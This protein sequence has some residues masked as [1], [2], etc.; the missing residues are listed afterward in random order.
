MAAEERMK[1]AFDKYQEIQF[2]TFRQFQKFL[3]DLELDE[4]ADEIDEHFY[5]EYF[6]RNCCTSLIGGCCAKSFRR[7]RM[8]QVANS[9][10]KQIQVEN[11]KTP[12]R[13]TD[14]VMFLMS[15]AEIFSGLG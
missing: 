11:K 4:R 7:V 1:A 9:L 10:A 14:L 15:S 12:E 2:L 6:K 8:K 13:P 5:E 3:K